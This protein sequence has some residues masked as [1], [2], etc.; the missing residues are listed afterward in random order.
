MSTDNSKLR[1]FIE[2]GRV[3]RM[4]T[5]DKHGVP[6]IVP[7]CYVFY[8]N[9]IYTPIDKKPKRS[10]TRDL[11]RVKN[12]LE[13]PN[14][15]LVVDDYYEEWSK[16]R[17]VIIHGKADLIDYGEEYRK[18]LEL[19][20]EKYHQY[21]EMNLLQLNLPVIKITVSKIISWGDI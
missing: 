12:I 1:N 18:S 9:Y 11:K 10:Q 3:A 16:L 2:T 15:S 7:M 5:A 21:K 17:H 13:N 4:A 8:E 14:V 20:C 6:L 19:L